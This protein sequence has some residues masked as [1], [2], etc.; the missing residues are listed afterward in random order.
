MA[1][2]AWLLEPETPTSFEPEAVGAAD[3]KTSLVLAFLLFGPAAVEDGFVNTEDTLDRL[4]R[5]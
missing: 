5:R 1:A 4:G 3:S 2:V